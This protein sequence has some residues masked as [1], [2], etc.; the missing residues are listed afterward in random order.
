MAW[1][2]S[3]RLAVVETGKNV[4]EEISATM[5]DITDLRFEVNLLAFAIANVSSWDFVVQGANFDFSTRTNSP[6]TVF[7]EKYATN[8]FPSE[9]NG[10]NF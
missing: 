8:Y 9:A 7:S 4:V 2:L 6:E 1:V 5:D 10:S 3:T